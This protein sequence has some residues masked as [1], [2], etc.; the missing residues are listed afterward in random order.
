M[1][2]VD[3]VAAIL[4]TGV[5]AYAVF[6]GADF[7]TGV[8]DLLAGGTRRGGAMRRLIDRSIGP[9]WEANHVWLIF[10]LV[11]LWT[12][13]PV[14]FAA[15][16][17]T[18]IVPWMAVGVGIVLRG[19]A[20]VF[21]KYASSVAA[22]RLHGVA[23]ATSSVVTPFFLGT[24]AG[25]IASGRVPASGGGDRWASWTGP[26]SL[27]GG[28]LAVLVTAFLAAVFLTRDAARE[29]DRAL[30]EQLRTRAL[31]TAVGTGVVAL[32]GI[33]VLTSDAPT[34]TAGLTG[35]GAPLV[36]LSAIGGGAT[37]WALWHRHFGRARVTAALSVATVVLGWGVGQYP[38][39]EVDAVTLADAAASPPVLWGLVI[40]FGV[41]VVVVVPSL[42]LLL[43][44]VETGTLR[45]PP[46]DPATGDDEV[47]GA[48]AGPA[49]RGG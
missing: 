10:V 42:V 11:V 29:G 25:A 47:T 20:F 8:W 22:A 48:D 34:L 23:F 41:A 37:I 24:I 44:L 45:E 9:V 38:W 15:M 5:V 12:A 21:R 13:F 33:A 7:G 1:T 4:F 31:G 26:T 30:A 14:A 36:V 2:L 28:V 46:H 27:L 49:T 16:M 19:G 39:L 35:R 43:Y 18:L 17:R 3:A 6:A 40:G 32:G